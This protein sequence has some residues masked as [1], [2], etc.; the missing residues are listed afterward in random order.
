MDLGNAEATAIA[1]ALERNTF[2]EEL[3]YVV[4]AGTAKERD[5][6]LTPVNTESK[7][8]RTTQRERRAKSAFAR[9]PM[10]PHSLHSLCAH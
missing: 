9:P 3:A 1:Q 5:S 4:S 8:Q 7:K 6:A 10:P 2:V